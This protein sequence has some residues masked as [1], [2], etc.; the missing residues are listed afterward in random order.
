MTNHLL[1]LEGYIGRLVAL[2]ERLHEAR[3]DNDDMEV[4]ECIDDLV[5]ESK[6]AATY[7]KGSNLG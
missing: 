2:I 3:N 6:Q 4:D 7:I 1:V 5:E